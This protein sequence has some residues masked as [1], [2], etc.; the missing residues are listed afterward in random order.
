MTK[1]FRV[2][3][4]SDLGRLAATTGAEVGL[5]LLDAH[6]HI[7][8]H[9]LPD[10]GGEISPE[11]IAG[12]DALLLLRPSVTERTLSGADR[13]RLVARWGVGHE[14]IDVSACTR[15]RVAVTIAPNGVRRPIAT[16]ML[17]QILALS[18]RLV[19]KNALMHAGGWNREIYL[20]DGLTG[21]ALGLVGLGNIG[22]ELLR[23][24]E[25][26]QMEHFVS[27]PFVTTTPEG[28]RAQF[29]DLDTL[30]ATSD[31]VC[32][33]CPLTEA[34]RHLLDA[35]RFARMKPSAHVIN[36]ARGAII[37]EAALIGAIER[38]QIAGAGLDVFEVEPLPT[39]SPL[40]RMDNVILGPHTLGF[41]RELLAG[42]GR[43]ACQAIIDMSLGCMP[44][45]LLNPEVALWPH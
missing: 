32:V 37:D 24:A 16:A 6:P 33:C 45:N 3:V 5:S 29:V 35:D 36:M 8:Y 21:A 17:A 23:L 31:F 11:H 26:L 1:S 44:D 13:L 38:G 42:N 15:R 40:R 4:S 43:D 7:D 18:S 41:S 9:V 10:D 20:G 19:A 12:C 22:A 34:T 28:V 14:N 39:S 2:A 27:D 25:P 30:L